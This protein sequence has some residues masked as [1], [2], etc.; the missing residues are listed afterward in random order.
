M[1]S[2][3][4]NGNFAQA[5]NNAIDSYLQK[6]SE[7]QLRPRVLPDQSYNSNNLPST[8]PP[9]LSLLGR[10]YDSNHLPSRAYAWTLQLVAK[11]RCHSKSSANSTKFQIQTISC[12]L[13]HSSSILKSTSFTRGGRGCDPVLVTSVKHR[14]WPM[15]RVGKRCLNDLGM[16]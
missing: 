13:K 7:K 16:L 1:W 14:Y 15:A 10:S 5:I 6:D 11:F 2:P 9:V 4:E 8:I 12:H 3:F